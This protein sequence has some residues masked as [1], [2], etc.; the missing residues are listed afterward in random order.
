MNVRF[1]AID[2]GLVHKVF[3]RV[4]TDKLWV[5]CRLWASDVHREWREVGEDVTCL[6][7]LAKACQ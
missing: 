3:T 1:R 7:C 4:D 6:V 5:W 2:D